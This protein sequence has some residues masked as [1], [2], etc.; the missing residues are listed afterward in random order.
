[1]FY[2]YVS[3]K[4][5]NTRYGVGMVVKTSVKADFT[6]IND[7]IC[8]IQIETETSN[9]KIIII[10]AYAPTEEVSKRNSQLR[11]Q[12]YDTLEQVIRSISVNDLLVIGGDFNAKTG[13]GYN[14]YRRNMGKYGKGKISD[15]GYELLDMCNRNDLI[16][17]NTIF[18]HK[19][20]HRTTWQAPE[21]PTQM[22]HDG[23]LR[24]NPVRNQIDYV[25]VRR[26]IIKQ[27]TNSRSYSVTKSDHT[28]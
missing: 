13:T 20:A 21:N 17:T 22:H 18:K 1:M 8:K 27:V 10:S 3:G 4:E 24:K 23:N 15:N 25:I 12:F 6:A 19:M 11:E 26:T 5:K 14:Q 16:L 2:H 28:I 7:R 9:Q